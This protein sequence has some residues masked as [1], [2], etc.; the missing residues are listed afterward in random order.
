MLQKLYFINP[1]PNNIRAKALCLY[2]KA[3]FITN[4]LQIIVNEATSQD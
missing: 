1:E 3:E 2:K 4:Y